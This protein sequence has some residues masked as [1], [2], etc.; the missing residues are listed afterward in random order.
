MYRDSKIPEGIAALV[1]SEEIDPSDLFPVL[2]KICGT[3]FFHKVGEGEGKEA[4]TVDGDPV[5]NAVVA[6]AR[7]DLANLFVVIDV[8]TFEIAKA[9][10]LIFAHCTSVEIASQ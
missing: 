1:H 8:F 2:R 7:E 9:C 4:I 3:E 6:Q 5:L 10:V